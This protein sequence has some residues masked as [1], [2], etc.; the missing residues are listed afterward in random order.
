MAIAIYCRKSVYRDTS[1]SIGNQVNMCREFIERNYGKDNTILIYDKDEGISGAT[2]DRPCFQKMMEDVESG[3]IHMV[4]CYMIDR[5]SRNIKDFCNIYFTLQEHNCRFV[6]V[7][8]NIDDTTAMGRAMLYI[9][10]VFANLERD[11]IRE[12]IIDNMGHIE[13]MGYWASGI[14]PYGYECVKVTVHGKKHTVLEI[15][16]E[17][18]S[19]YLQMVDLFLNRKMTLYKIETELSSAGIRS[20]KGAVIDSSRIWKYLS[21]PVYMAADETAYLHLQKLGCQMMHDKSCFDG[22]YGIMVRGRFQKNG[23]TM[24]QT[25]RNQWRIYVGTHKPLISSK[26]WIALQTR[27]QENVYSKTKKEP[28]GMCSGILRCQCGYSMRSKSKKNPSVGHVYNSYICTRREN[29]YR[30]ECNA[31]MVKCS[32]VDDKVIDKL[33]EIAIDRETLQKYMTEGKPKHRISKKDLTKKLHTLSDKITRLAASLAEAE[34]SAARKY[35]IGEIEKLDEQKMAVNQRLTEYQLE[36]RK[37]SRQAN[38]IE[39]LYNDIRHMLDNIDYMSLP[40][41]NEML[42]GFVKEVILY[43]NDI[44]LL[45]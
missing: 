25:E 26:E 15:N 24:K 4:V 31:P 2:T 18:S 13:Q 30:G 10:Q 34:S 40:E 19:V 41:K 14:A 37:E 21:N 9:C 36:E 23:K 5:L 16:P 38:D 22:Q 6:S 32:L 42:K 33:R 11:N 44:K 27:F 39:A 28:Y 7:K 20:K 1:D 3:I 29:R 8:E 43:P 12:R 45:L 35:I 17:E